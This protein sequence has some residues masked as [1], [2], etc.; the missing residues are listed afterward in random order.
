MTARFLGNLLGGEYVHLKYDP[1]LAEK[2]EE[3]TV[4][5]YLYRAPD[6]LF[7][8]L[9]AIRQGFALAPRDYEFKHSKTFNYYEEKAQAD[10]KGFWGRMQA[11]RPPAT[12]R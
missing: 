10:L 8:N 12:A 6:G 4:L 1:S 3:G 11:G 5:A 7:V 2:D 9:E